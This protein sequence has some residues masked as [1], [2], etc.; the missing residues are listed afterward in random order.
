M[1]QWYQ[2]IHVPGSQ[3][4]APSAKRFRLGTV[5][6]D[7]TGC[8]F[9]YAK[10]VASLA[11]GDWVIFK[12]ETFVPVRLVNTPLSGK[13]GISLSA[14]T[15]ASN[16]SWYLIKGGSKQISA[17]SG[18]VN[19]ATDASGDTKLVYQSSSTGRGTTATA[20]AGKAIFGAIAVGN[21]A[22]NVGDVLLDEPFCVATSTL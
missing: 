3:T 15:S 13:V 21:P 12:D 10:G 5:K 19:L 17:L 6:R 20:A 9:I 8:E 1:A 16:F 14:N 4:G 18:L 22:A 11:V 7:I 2:A